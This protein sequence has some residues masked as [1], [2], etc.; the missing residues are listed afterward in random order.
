MRLGQ[1]GLSAVV[2]PWSD[3]RGNR[4]VL[5]VSQIAVGLAPLFFLWSSPEHPYRLA[6]AWLLW[7]AYAGINIC[8]PNLTMLLAPSGERASHLSAYYAMSSI[9]LTLGTLAGGELFD[10][11]RRPEFA[12]FWST[13]PVDPFAA[14]FVIAIVTRTAGALLLLRVEER[15]Y[16]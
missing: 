11:V 7:S 1:A 16:L 6:G 4:N 12:S 14:S 3:R 13:S 5:I 15:R 2:G 8:L 9:F 10:Y